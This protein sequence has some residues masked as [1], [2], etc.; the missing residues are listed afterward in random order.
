MA[1]IRD[2]GIN[3]IPVAQPFAYYACGAA[4]NCFGCACDNTNREDTSAGCDNSDWGYERK[5]DEEKDKTRQ[6]QQY[7]GAFAGHQVA[8]LKRQLRTR[9]RRELDH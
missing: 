7:T 8:R 3:V 2:L 5:E 9:L 1:R 4:S 6:E